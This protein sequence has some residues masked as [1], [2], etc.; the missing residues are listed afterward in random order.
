MC[1]AHK[2]VLQ[3]PAALNCRDTWDCVVIMIDRSKA[4]S[5]ILAENIV[6]IGLGNK[7]KASTPRERRVSYQIQI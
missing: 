5:L 7:D 2:K 1:P 3:K 4:G 6:L